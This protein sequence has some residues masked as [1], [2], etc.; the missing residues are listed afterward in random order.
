VKKNSEL[1]MGNGEKGDVLSDFV[2]RDPDAAVA[3]IA[4]VAQ[5]MAM[6]DGGRALVPV[7][8]RAINNPKQTP[9]EKVEASTTLNLG[10]VV[11]RDT[12]LM[13]FPEKGLIKVAE[14]LKYIRIGKTTWWEWVRDDFAPK[15]V[16]KGCSTFWRCDELLKFMDEFGR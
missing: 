16:K 2:R 7:F 4:A 10:T 13:P 5:R 9:R 8:R 15:P 11:D 3:V 14:V 1:R 12:P 6:P